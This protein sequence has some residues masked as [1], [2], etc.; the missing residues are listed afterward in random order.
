M[1]RLGLIGAGGNGTEHAR[2]YASCPRCKLVAVAD[3]I[4]ERAR[5]LAAET[6]ALPLTDFRDFLDQVDAVVIS[7]PNNLHREHAVACAEARKHVYCEKPMGLSAAEAGEIASAVNRAGVRSVVGFGVR[8]ANTIQT[9]FRL[10]REG[11]FGR[12]VSIWCR[13]LSYMD[14]AKA[15]PWRRDPRQ[16]GGVMMEVNIH[17][18]EWMMA[19][20]GEVK[21]VYARMQAV[22]ASLPRSNDHVW[23]ILNFADGAVAAHEGSWRSA[24]QTWFRGA[25]GT[26]GG[27]CTD[28]WGTKLYYAKLGENRAEMPLDEPFDLRGHFLDC[29]EHGATPAADVNWGLKV[30]TVAEAIFQSA[31]QGLA[32]RIGESP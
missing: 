26:A 1:I 2:Y 5:K 32:V 24:T 22:D 25:H 29:I 10:A 15:E 17:E 4:P 28:E 13:R 27:A 8:F 31:A 6:G 19:L 7:T 11:R 18:L 21:S 14:M 20:G 16:S 12:I 30:M 9:I 3:V 23:F